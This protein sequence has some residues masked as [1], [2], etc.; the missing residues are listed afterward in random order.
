MSGHSRLTGIGPTW[1]CPG[2][3]GTS[4][5]LPNW[6][7]LLFPQTGGTYKA[8]VR[9]GSEIFN[10]RCEA[11]DGD[12]LDVAGLAAEDDP[13]DGDFTVLDGDRIWLEM[14][15]TKDP[16]TNIITV[17]SLTIEA[18]NKPG[19]DWG[20]G[21]YEHDGGSGGGDDPHYSP[22]KVRKVLATIF[23]I[24]DGHGTLEVDRRVLGPLVIEG[25]RQFHLSSSGDDRQWLATLSI[26][27][28]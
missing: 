2:A 22:F 14:E 17:S 4:L 27:P 19:S 13:T 16:D 1:P 12:G 28:L 20:G 5:E 10:S 7:T 24:G 9:K 18:D 6:E 25:D 26:F 8:C 23:D 3:T 11:T 21:E 15:V